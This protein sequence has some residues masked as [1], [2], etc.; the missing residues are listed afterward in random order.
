M[1][2]EDTGFAYAVG[3]SMGGETCG[4]AL[5]MIDIREPLNPKFAG[6]FA[7]PALGLQR[8][9]YTHDA[10][11]VIYH[12]PGRALPRPRDLLRPPPRPRSASPT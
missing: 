12:G 2:N 4:G 6:C 7:D 8:T 5:H 9:G 1:I 3:N 11:C 10:Q